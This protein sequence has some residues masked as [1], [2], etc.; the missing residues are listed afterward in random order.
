MKKRKIICII[1]GGGRGSRL[2]PL[3]RERCKPAVPLAG[4]YR[5]VDIPISN[6]LNAGMNQIFVLTQFNTASLH[7]HIQESYKFDPFAGGFVDILSAE[8]TDASSNWYQGT[9]DAVR[10][11]MQHF[12][13]GEDDLY[14][15]L[16]GD[17]LYRMDLQDLVRA[18]DDSGAAVTL[19]AK[20]LGLDQAEG[21]GLMRVN[22]QLE[23]TEFVE[24]PTDPDVI[25][26]L[27]V[28]ENVRSQMK[29]PEDQDYCLA[30]MGIYVF[31]AKVLIDALKTECADFGKEIIP[32]LL[33]KEKLCSYVFDD[34]WEDIGTVRAFFDANLRLT[35]PV[36]PF[37]FF[38]ED[39]RIY[40]RARYLPAA[41]I[42]SGQI[43]RAIIS[44]GCIIT[45]VQMTCS[46][47][48]VRSVIRN[49]S[50]LDNV[51]MMGADCFEGDA[52]FAENYA[53]GRPH[54][55]VG[56]GCFI[57]DAILDKNVRIG[58][59]VVLDPTGLPDNFGP[60]VDIAIRDGVLVVCKDTVVPSGF[61]L[62]A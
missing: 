56:Q 32:G 31:D 44:D 29:A 14:V 36:P 54:L 47:L 22:D 34:Y 23:I 4:K 38:D 40:T 7:R 57:K 3:T 39:A 27:A 26:G 43:N 17:Q 9:A 41:K 53:K 10:Q 16:S 35:D 21:L 46:L 61:V 28:G 59:N 52:E 24:K 13:G 18:H 48:G 12:N 42:N 37:N 15:I 20:P 58:D 51:V 2:S 50:T 25:A 6:C 5:L 11:N 1:M 49:K 8:Q 30:S 33:G 19:T 60:G 62:R 55:G 45:D